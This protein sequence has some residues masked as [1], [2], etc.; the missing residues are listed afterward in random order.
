MDFELDEEH[1]LLQQSV[2]KFVASEIT[3]RAHEI[4]VT[5]E[6]P[7]DALHAMAPLGFLGLN[8]PEKYGGAG[9]DQLGAAILLEE[10]GRGGCGSTGLIVAAHLGLAC[11]PLALFGSEAQ[12]QRWLVPMAQGKM[13]GALGLTEPG[14]GSDLRNT[15]TTAVRRGDE[16]VING[17]KMWM[18]NGA[19]AGIAILLCRTGDHHSQIIVP[20]DTR[21]VQF[22]RPEAKM[23]LHGSHT[24]AVSLEDVRV[25]ADH[26]LG[27]EGKGL[28]QTMQV[29]D[30]GRVGIGALSLGLAQAAYLAARDYAHTRHTFGEPLVQHQ[31]IAFMLADMTTEIAAARWL[32]Y[33]AAWLKDQGRR[34]IKEASIAKLFASE[35]AEKCARDAIQIH[36]GYGYSQEYPVDRIYRDARLMTIGEGT[37]EIQRLVIS[38]ESGRNG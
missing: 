22:G 30:S 5:G 6:F 35:A 17:S 8:V 14:A 13:L 19:E 9:S 10:I 21:G 12:K 31:A 7:W 37:S 29:L 20:T 38:R 4:D 32:V 16:W 18:T 25:P 34:F 2:R 26:L 24:Y 1:R 36:G 23:G 15:R 11:G 3:P 28:P 27:T 33:H